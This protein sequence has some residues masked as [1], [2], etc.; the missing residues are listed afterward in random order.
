MRAYIFIAFLFLAANAISQPLRDI[1]YSYLYNPDQEFTFKL[2]PV[3]L[4]ESWLVLYQLNISDTLLKPGELKI[5][6]EAY[7]S[8]TKKEFTALDSS[9]VT[10][11]VFSK[12]AITGQFRIPRASAPKVI[13]ARVS[14]PALKKQWLFFA[15]LDENYSLT[16]YFEGQREMYAKSGEPL[17]I[18]EPK[19]L[20][21]FY[22]NDIFPP[23][24]PAFAESQGKV[25]REM[26]ADST[27][28]V[29]SDSI[30]FSSQ[31]LYLLQEDTLKPE[32]FSIRIQ[33]DYPRFRRIQNLFGPM[34]Y[35]C[36]KQEYDALEKSKGDKK[37]FDKTILGITRDPE[38]AKRLIKNYFNRVEFANRIFT[39]YKEGWK[40]DRG[41]IYI[42]FGPPEEVTKS[43]D[44]E[45]WQYKNRS[46]N[47]TFEFV[48]AGSVFDP[49]NYVLIRDRKYQ[50]VW[51]E[52]V[53][54]W[55]NARF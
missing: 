10:S 54:L 14:D 17:K 46:F 37:V 44:R 7:E 30:S 1:N 31:G 32:G 12:Y 36:T 52:V 20:S 29:S 38:R 22:Y 8:L 50:T 19:R 48:K 15:T 18:I 23:A 40:T 51:Y 34:V 9:I 49:E 16:N 3:R 26:V 41:M 5:S 35:I 13:A 21:L 42:I 27:S 6:W 2:Q 45:F 25:S 24:T 33:D 55:R 53:D 39:S 28:I 11:P 47:I 43:Y 4:S